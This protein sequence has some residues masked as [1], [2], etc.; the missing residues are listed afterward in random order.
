MISNKEKLINLIIKQL[1]IEKENN[2]EEVKF[3][4]LDTDREYQVKLA[5]KLW[6]DKISI[7][8]RFW[9]PKEFYYIED[10]LLEEE[11]FKKIKTIKYGNTNNIFLKFNEW[12][13]EFKIYF[14]ELNNKILVFVGYEICKDNKW[15]I[16]NLK[17]FIGIFDLILK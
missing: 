13:K 11:G 12:K 4:D 10:V 17:Y 7:E 9:Y 2:P 1:G 14:N 3:N 15:N 8:D 5:K 16:T 6:N